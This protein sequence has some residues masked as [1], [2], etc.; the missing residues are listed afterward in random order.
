MHV[1]Q[2]DRV[3]YDMAEIVKWLEVFTKRFFLTSQF[4]RSA[5]PN[6]P[7]VTSGGALSPRGDWRMPSDSLATPWL[8]DIAKLK[9]QLGLKA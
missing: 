7:K 4:K 6:G 8:D 3:A 5:V 2:K 9:A 1:A